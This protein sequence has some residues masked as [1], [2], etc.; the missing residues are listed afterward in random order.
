MP[1]KYGTPNF[2][3]LSAIEG[4]AESPIWIIGINPK[5]VPGE[6]ATS[7]PNPINWTNTRPHAPH[8]QRLQRVIGEQ[9][10]TC[11]FKE[12]GIAHTDLLKCGSPS[13]SEVEMGAVEHCK[14]FL[15]DQI[16]THK[17]KLL[18]VLSSAAAG[19]IHGEAGLPDGSTEGT[20]K[21]EHHQCYVVLSGYSS[22]FQDRYAR[23]RLMKD[24]TNACKRVGLNPLA[25][26]QKG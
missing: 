21:I 9:W 6:H 23:L 26:N 25:Q 15:L 8:F 24:F 14:G 18:L 4:D 3:P 16:R 1:A 13:Y 12:G 11:L 2:D 10:Y 7:Q 17:P 20:W 5:T 19:I 22:P